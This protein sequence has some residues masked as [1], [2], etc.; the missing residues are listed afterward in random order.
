RREVHR[1][2][3][4]AGASQHPPFLRPQREDVPRALEVARHD[5]RIGDRR[6]REGAIV[7]ARTG[8]DAGAVVDRDGERRVVTAGA[9]HHLRDLQL[10]EPPAGHRQAHDSSAMRH[11]EVDRV[12]CAPLGGDHEVA[13][14]LTIGVVDDQDHLAGADVL[15]RVLDSA[16]HGAV[17]LGELFVHRSALSISRCTYLATRSTSRLT[18]SPTRASASVATA[19]VC[20]I[21]AIET[22]SSCSS[23]TVRLTPS[24]VI[25]PFDTTASSRSAGTSSRRSPPPVASGASA[26]IS[27]TPSTWPCT[28]WPPRRAASDTGRSRLTACPTSRRPRLVRA[29]VSELRSNAKC[30]SSCSTTVRQVPLTATDA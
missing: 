7:R 25:E 21:N 18:G 11:H 8:G 20:G 15:Q 30:S 23:A 14:V 17:H 5:A 12:G 9:R 24:T 4:V 16:E 28:K 2:L 27:P 1:R 22:P 6:C 26:R 19:I 13:F 10:I 3:G 29:S